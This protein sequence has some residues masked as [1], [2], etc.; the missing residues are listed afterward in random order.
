M[1]ELSNPVKY[2]LCQNSPLPAVEWLYDYVVAA[3]GVYKRASNDYFWA[4]LPVEQARFEGDLPKKLIPYRQAAFYLR[5][6]RLPV[7]ALAIIIKDART[8]WSDYGKFIENYYIINNQGVALR[9]TQKGTAGSVSYNLGNYNMQNALM[10]VHTHPGMAYFSE[11]DNADEQGFRLYGVLGNIN[12]ARPEFCLRLGVYGDFIP[13]RADEVFED[14]I[15]QV[16]DDTPSSLG[17]ELL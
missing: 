10:E 15:Y 1:V 16:V 8:H 7:S 12:Q 5:R 4:C 11:T 2:H 14:D 13:L 6:P 3:N 9:P 17:V